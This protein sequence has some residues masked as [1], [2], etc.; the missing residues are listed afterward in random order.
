MALRSPCKQ[1]GAQSAKLQPRCA[2]CEAWID[3]PTAYT[4]FDVLGFDETLKLDAEALRERFYALS[5]QTHPDRFANAPGL[6]Q[7]IAARWSTAVNRAYQT[8]REPTSLARYLMELHGIADSSKGVP[9]ELAE[10]YFDLQDRLA[11]G[12]TGSLEAFA[13]DLR[14]QHAGLEAEWERLQSAWDPSA[15]KKAL[16]PIAKHLTLRRF[17]DSMLHDIE[18]R[19]AS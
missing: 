4:H 14:A 7:Q 13:A 12:E 17:L 5:R 15:P 16:E 1:C 11:E 8:L 2:Q 3:L 10:S 9:L 19:Q 18:K 6:E